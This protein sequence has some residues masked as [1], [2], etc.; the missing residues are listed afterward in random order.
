MEFSSCQETCGEI[1][2]QRKTSAFC[3][4]KNEEGAYEYY[5]D[6]LSISSVEL[7]TKAHPFKSLKSATTEIHN[8]LSFDQEA[9]VSIFLKE[10]SQV[11]IDK[12]QMRFI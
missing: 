6:S 12:G 8:E 11:V 2:I 9:Q 5:I 1:K 3:R 4:E 7:G 10:N